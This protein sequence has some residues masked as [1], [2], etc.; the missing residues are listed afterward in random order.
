[1]QPP[2]IVRSSHQTL[3]SALPPLFC[4]PALCR[5]CHRGGPR[6]PPLPPHGLAGVKPGRRR[7]PEASTPLPTAA[8]AAATLCAREHCVVD[9]LRGTLA[10][11]RLCRCFASVYTTV[12]RPQAAMRRRE[13]GG[14]N[15]EIKML[16]HFKKC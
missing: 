13:P 3:D 6:A 4:L 5:R 9:S 2:T 15:V 11:L 1:M 16:K 12:N 7:F 10:T 8:R 14:E